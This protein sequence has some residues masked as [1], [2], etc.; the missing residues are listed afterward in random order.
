MAAKVLNIRSL[1]VGLLLLLARLGQGQSHKDLGDW[2]QFQAL[3]ELGDEVRE[4]VRETGRLSD[5][6]SIRSYY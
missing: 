6:L 2:G 4:S 5:L 3:R 1:T